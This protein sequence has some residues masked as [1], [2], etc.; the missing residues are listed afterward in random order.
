MKNLMIKDKRGKGLGNGAKISLWIVGIVVV[1]SV[2]VIVGS[3]EK[4]IAPEN[5]ATVSTAAIV[6]GIKI[7]LLKPESYSF[8]YLP[9]ALC[10]PSWMIHCRPKPKNTVPMKA[11]IAANKIT[12]ETA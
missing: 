9:P 12:V 2:V 3:E 6:I 1:G 5:I 10:T 7:V 11:N 4:N 8:N